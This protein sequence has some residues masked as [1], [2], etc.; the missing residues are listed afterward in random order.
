MIAAP[1]GGL[2][3]T[4]FGLAMEL[5]MYGVSHA[6][7]LLPGAGGAI[8]GALSGTHKQGLVKVGVGAALGWFLMAI[9]YALPGYGIAGME[10]LTWGGFYG[11]PLGAILV[12]VTEQVVRAPRVLI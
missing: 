2:L 5:W 3:G 1:F 9:V 11:A 6:W 8:A 10:A 7:V 4:T 12:A